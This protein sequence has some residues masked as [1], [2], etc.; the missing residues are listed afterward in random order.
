VPE[1]AALLPYQKRWF[2]DTS[3]VRVW[4]KSRRIGASWCVAGEL[5]LGA[6]KTVAAGGCDGW[7]TS[8]N[9]QTTEDFIRDVAFWAGHIDK[10]ASSIEQNVLREGGR[11]V[12]TYRVTFASGHRVTALTSRPTNLRNKKGHIVVDEAAFHDDLDELLKAALA[13]LIW[14]GSAR[15]SILS[16]HNGVDNPFN[17]LVS[18]VRAKKLPYS[19]HRTTLDD[20]IADGLCRRI[21]EVN[22]QPYNRKVEKDWRKSVI[23]FYGDAAE[24]ELFCVPARSGGVYIPRALVERQ[25]LPG[26]VLRL[27]SPAKDFVTWDEAKRESHVQDWIDAELAPILETLDSDAQ[28]FLGEDFGRVSDRTVLVVGALGADLRRESKLAIEL[29][30]IPFEQQKQILFYVGDRLPNFYRGAFDATG[31]GSYLAEVALQRWG[32]SI[33]C[34]SLT[35]KWYSEHFPPF[36]AALSDSKMT[37]ISDPDHLMDFGQVQIF[38]G[39]PRLSKAKNQSKDKTRK[40]RHGDSAVAYLLA[41]Y[42][43]LGEE[44]YIGLLDEEMSEGRGSALPMVD[45][46]EL[47]DG[48]LL[49]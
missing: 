36:K 38:N 1:R 45:G 4:E 27:D 24:E 41:H 2:L 18:K 40:P 7:Y 17:E 25:M 14:G 22:R 15:V 46:I 5:A 35:D 32:S 10:A 20:A 26:P 49:I 23:E 19:L 16:T 47:D 9:Q 30:D 48:V 21:C 37:L 44:V 42:A 12:L 8:Y 3:Q 33:E 11:D 31:N 34:I 13:V 43:S 28:H 6:A 29:C 39:Q